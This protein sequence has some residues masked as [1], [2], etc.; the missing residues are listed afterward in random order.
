MYTFRVVTYQ[1]NTFFDYFVCNS[2]GS[3]T[4]GSSTTD[5]TWTYL[6]TLYHDLG[7]FSFQ[8]RHI[9]LQVDTKINVIG[10]LKVLQK[11]KHMTK[12]WIMKQLHQIWGTSS[13]HATLYL[14]Q[15]SKD[16]FDNRLKL[17]REI[18]I[19]ISACTIATMININVSL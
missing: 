9:K 15:S 10:L 19:V 2:L 16:V 7:L 4:T 1:S 17:L 8:R 5:S 3:S 13:R 11:V 18:I 12:M 6:Y 14:N